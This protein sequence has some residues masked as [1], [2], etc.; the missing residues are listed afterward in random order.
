M[1]NQPTVKCRQCGKPISRDIAIVLKE[2]VYFCSEQCK[3]DY[4]DAHTHKPKSVVVKPPP[5]QMADRQ[6]L[7]DYIHR[8]APT[9]NMRLV[10]GQLT[11]L[12]RDNPDMTFG[13]IAYT[14]QYLIKSGFDMSESPLGMVKYRYDE[15]ANYYKW[16]KQAKEN[17]E[18]WQDND[19]V[20]TIVKREYEEDVFK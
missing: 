3:Q 12:M 13:G 18:Q 7:L 5:K 17:I 14:I 8:I 19:G 6:K 4:I 2:R 1:P 16:L 10:V 15:A 20:E 11:N 9:V